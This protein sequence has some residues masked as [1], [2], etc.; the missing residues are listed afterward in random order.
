MLG[1]YRAAA[2]LNHVAGYFSI[3]G[4]PSDS[5][6]N[7]VDSVKGLKLLL[8]RLVLGRFPYVVSFRLDD[9]TMDLLRGKD[10]EMT[11]RFR[12]SSET[13]CT[14]RENETLERTDWMQLV[15]V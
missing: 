14:Q 12:G 4:F 10:S 5:I 8:A 15:G 2:I 1:E 9:G 11:M 6:V 3:G 7:L 13:D